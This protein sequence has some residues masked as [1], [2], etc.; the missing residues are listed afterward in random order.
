MLLHTLLSHV[1][2]RQDRKCGTGDMSVIWINKELI[3]ALVK[4]LFDSK[5]LATP[6]TTT[7]NQIPLQRD[8]SEGQLS[9]MLNHCSTNSAERSLLFHC[10]SC[11]AIPAFFSTRKQWKYSNSI[12]KKKK[13]TVKPYKRCLLY[14]NQTYIMLKLSEL[15]CWFISDMYNNY[16][17]PLSGKD[18]W[19]TKILFLSLCPPPPLIFPLHSLLFIL[20]PP[21]HL[22]KQAQCNTYCSRQKQG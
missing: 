4:F 12:K 18:N 15:L 11:F 22:A 3:Q 17:K 8:C 2:P 10:K 5:S 9:V 21:S 19:R 6:A 1:L 16:E 20:P 13:Q 7:D 14:Q